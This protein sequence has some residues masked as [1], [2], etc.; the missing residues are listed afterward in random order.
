MNLK[1]LLSFM[2]L[3]IGQE[4]YAQV[5]TEKAQERDVKISGNYY[6]GDGISDKE[7]DAKLL[8][9]DELKLMISEDLKVNNQNISSIGFDGFEQNIGTIVM[10]IQNRFR[11]IA[12]ILK[13]EIKVESNGPKKLMVIRIMPD[14]TVTNENTM[15]EST[16]QTQ[17]NT[18]N[19]TATKTTTTQSISNINSPIISQLIKLT[20]SKDVGVLLN[21]NKLNGNLIY[22][23]LNTIDDIKNCY[24][25][26]IKSGKLVDVLDQGETSIRNG[27]ITGDNVDYTLVQDII[28]WVYINF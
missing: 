6:Y 15:E 3:F 27:L 21:E 4:T 7:K 23:R 25:V 18:N 24:F 1:T 8:A 14:G 5:S 12:F 20:D 11:V 9:L 13:N 28:Y 22:G 2:I 26:I 19:T 10:P 17:S 16:K